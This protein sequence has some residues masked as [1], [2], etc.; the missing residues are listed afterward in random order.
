MYNHPIIL[1][2]VAAVACYIQ[3]FRESLSEKMCMRHSRNVI[4]DMINKL[5]LTL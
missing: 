5:V 1:R 3:L 2:A 4:W